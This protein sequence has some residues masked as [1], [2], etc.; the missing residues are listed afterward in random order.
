MPELL[1]AIEQRGMPWGIVT[2]KSSRFTP[3][4]VAALGL[5]ARAAC[6]VCGDTTPHIKPHPA[7]LLHAAR[8]LALEPAQCW[9]VGDDLRDVQAAHAAGMRSVAVKYGYLGTGS[10]PREWNAHAVIAYPMDL[11]S[12]L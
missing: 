8:Q 3:R 7:S 2:N 11:I 6:V 9:Y 4:I 5:E 1:A 10:A 12:H